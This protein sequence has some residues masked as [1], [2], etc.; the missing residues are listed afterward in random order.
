V[1][2]QHYTFGSRMEPKGRWMS[3][4]HG[5]PPLRGAQGIAAPAQ[6]AAPEAGAWK[7]PLQLVILPSLRYV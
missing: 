1:A 2:R 3:G 4:E 6:K 7:A 5:G